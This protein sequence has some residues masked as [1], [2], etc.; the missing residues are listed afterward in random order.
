MFIKGDGNWK[1]SSLGKEDE[2]YVRVR[3]TADMVFISTRESPITVAVDTEAWKSFKKGIR[4]GDF[5]TET[6]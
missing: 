6:A 4:N 5:D 1:R 3:I 2:N